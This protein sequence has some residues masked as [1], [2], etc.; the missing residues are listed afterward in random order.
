LGELRLVVGNVVLVLKAN[1]DHEH[2][3]GW[4]CGRAPVLPRLRVW[5][6]GPPREMRGKWDFPWIYHQR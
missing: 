2:S 6:Y 3:W 4:K 1:V 5:L